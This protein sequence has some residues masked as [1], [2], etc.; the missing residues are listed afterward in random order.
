[1]RLL[2]SGNSLDGEVAA[3]QQPK[4]DSRRNPSSLVGKSL[5]L[6]R[7]YKNFASSRTRRQGNHAM[8]LFTTKDTKITKAREEYEKIIFRTSCP[9]CAS[10][11]RTWVAN[12]V[13]RANSQ[14]P[15]TTKV[16]TPTD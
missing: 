14:R 11:R 5:P 7:L 15:P 4:S 10:W 8:T 2:H 16:R 13:T 6:H 3:G 12:G 1:V 9:S